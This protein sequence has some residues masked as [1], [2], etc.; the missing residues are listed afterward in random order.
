MVIV[1]IVVLGSFA[2]P[3]KENDS[4]AAVD[5]VN[6]NSNIKSTA[7]HANKAVERTVHYKKG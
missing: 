3:E 4:P 7:N 5:P 1:T 6:A 2:R